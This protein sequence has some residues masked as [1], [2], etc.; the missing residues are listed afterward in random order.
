MWERHRDY[1]TVA[2]YVRTF[3]AATANMDVKFLAELRQYDSKIGVSPL[4]MAQLHWQIDEPDFDEVA[5]P[6]AKVRRMRAVDPA[7]AHG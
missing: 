3:V 4:A 1:G 6:S 7:Q 5:A 2:L